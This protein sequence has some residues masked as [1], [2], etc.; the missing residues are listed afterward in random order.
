[1]RFACTKYLHLFVQIL[2]IQ[3]EINNWMFFCFATSVQITLHLRKVVMAELRHRLRFKKNNPP[4][5]YPGNVHTSHIGP[6]GPVALPPSLDLRFVPR[7]KKY[8]MYFGCAWVLLFLLL[9]FVAGQNLQAVAEE[10]SKL[11]G[12]V[13]GS[14]IS[15]GKSHTSEWALKGL[16]SSVSLSLHLQYSAVQLHLTSA[17]EVWCNCYLF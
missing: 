7:L 2:L 8:L 4:T 14:S 17:W 5:A 6:Q 13:I 12:P 11:Y 15:E 3:F 10:K 16:Y 1:M 9:V